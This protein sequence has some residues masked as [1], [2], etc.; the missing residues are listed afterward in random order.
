MKTKHV[1]KPSRSEIATAINRSTYA[2]TLTLELQT[3]ADIRAVPREL[4]KFVGN[5]LS[6]VTIIC[7]KHE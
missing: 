7:L 5:D 4:E 1:N 3:T 6:K 2:S